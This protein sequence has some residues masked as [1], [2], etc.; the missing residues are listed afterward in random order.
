MCLALASSDARFD[1]ETG[2]KLKCYRQVGWESGGCFPFYAPD[3]F[4]TVQLI[5]GNNTAEQQWRPTG[6]VVRYDPATGKVVQNVSDVKLWTGGGAGE[7]PDESSQTRTSVDDARLGR[8]L[9]RP[10]SR[11]F[12]AAADHK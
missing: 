2:S 1:P 9:S 6:C 8:F 7:A 5:S 12:R 4:R 10:L 11:I 3:C